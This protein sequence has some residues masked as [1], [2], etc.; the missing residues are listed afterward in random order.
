[1]E[2]PTRFTESHDDAAPSID[3]LLQTNESLEDVDDHCEPD[4]ATETSNDYQLTRD[5]EKREI[6]PPSIFGF[7]DFVEYALVTALDYEESEPL[8]YKSN[9]AEKWMLA[10]KEEFDSLIK[11][12]TWELVENKAKHK[13]VT[14]KW[15]FKLNEGNTP[16]DPPIYKT[17]LV[18]MGYTQ[19]KG[20]D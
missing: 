3:P 2:P 16:I 13:V 9:N 15:I 19:T 4:L 1:M 7:A 12:N 17:R 8:T 20:V 5:R 14:C 10:M 18:A 11:N 6:K